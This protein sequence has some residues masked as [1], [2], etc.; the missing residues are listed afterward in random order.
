LT[1]MK[2][3]D[4]ELLEQALANDEAEESKRNLLNSQDG[5]VSQTNIKGGKP[6]GSKDA[7]KPTG[8]VA[9][10]EAD[11]NSPKPIEIEYPEDVK[12]EKDFLLIEKNF[13]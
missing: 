6:P 11:K 9:V 7:K 12:S 1:K 10:V 4:L 5:H 2:D 3:A 8:K 13:N